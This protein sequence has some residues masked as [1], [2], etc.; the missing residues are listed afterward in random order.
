M[1]SFSQRV[2]VGL[3]NG[4]FAGGWNSPSGSLNTG[5]AFSGAENYS[6]WRFTGVTIPQG[7]V[8]TAATLTLVGDSTRADVIHVKLKGVAEDNTADFTSDPDSRAKTTANVNWDQS[9]ETAGNTYVLPDITSIIQEIVNRGGWGSGNA[10]AIITDD[11]GTSNSN[12]FNSRGWSTFNPGNQPY[13]ALLDITYTPP[14]HLITK[15][16]TYLVTTPRAALTKMLR[17]S[18]L[19]TELNPVPFVGIKVAKAGHNVINTKNPNNLNFSTDYNTL[20]YFSEGHATIHV[21]HA[22]ATLYKDTATFTHNLGYLPIAFVVA[23]DDLMTKYQLLG[24]NQ[25][26]S[27]TYR[28]FYYYVTTTQLIVIAEGFTGLIS[29]VTYDVDFYYKIFRNNL[30]L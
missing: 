16:L 6:A 22:V 10:L 3:N 18:I 23:K 25:F 4:Y 20:K 8:I 19:D 2:T 28:S 29:G 21:S 26:G 5:R 15:N 1:S 24:R 27:S 14:A 11:N 30:N 12:A 9:G 13:A 17:Y 7:S